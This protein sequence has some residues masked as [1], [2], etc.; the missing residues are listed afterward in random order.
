MKNYTVSFDIGTNSTGWACLDENYKILSKKMPV[1]S[2]VQPKKRVHKNFWGVSL[3]DAGKTAAETRTFRSTRRRYRRRK[4]RLDLLNQFFEDA[5]MEVDPNFLIRLNL[6]ST[7][8]EEP[9]GRSWDYILFMDENYKDSDYYKEFPTIYHLRKRLV[10][11]NQK[12]DIRLVYL[13]IHHILKYRGNFLYEDSFFDSTNE[14]V[15]LESAL[16]DLFKNNLFEL[17]EKN[18]DIDIILEKESVSQKVEDLMTLHDTKDKKHKEL[19]KLMLG[20][21]GSL[22]NLFDNE[23]LSTSTFTVNNEEWDSW[24]SE[25]EGLNYDEES[26]LLDIKKIFNLIQLEL[27]IEGASSEVSLAKVS[28]SMVTRYENHK[29]QLKKLK[30]FVKENCPR[31]TFIRIFKEESTKNYFGYITGV[32]KDSREKATTD[33]FYEFL[34]KELKE[35]KETDFYKEMIFLMDQREYLLKQRINVNGVI[36]HQ[37]HG[38][39]LQLILDNQ[40]KYYPFLQEHKEKIMAILNF[41]IPYYVGPLT[42][43]Q[44]MSPFAWM[45]KNTQEK[46]YP[47]NFDEVVNKEASA[48]EFINRMKSFDTYLPGES[49]L[50]KFS[51]LYQK[52][53]VLNEL[54]KIK[55]NRK[56]LTIENK[57]KIFNEIFKK[58]KNIDLGK[59]RNWWIQNNLGKN[60][61]HSS[62]VV[63]G[64]QKESSFAS[65]LSTYID[66]VNIFGQDVVDDRRNQSLLEEVVLNISLFEDKK[67]LKSRLKKSS[68][69]I[70]P[71]QMKQLLK[72]RYQGWGRL[73]QEF[74]DGTKFVSKDSEHPEKGVFSFIDVLWYTNL[75]LMQV[76]NSD[77]YDFKE[78]IKEAWDNSEMSDPL[79]LENIESIAGSPAIK[80][81]IYQSV[82]IIKEIVSITKEEPK[83]IVL[84]VA[85]EDG[86]KARPIDRKKA[87]EN[88]YNDLKNVKTEYNRELAKSLKETDKLTNEWLYL[89]YRQNGKCMYSGKSL[90]SPDSLTRTKLEIDHILPQSYI[91][92]DSLANKALVYREENQRKSNGLLDEQIINQQMPFWQT[93]LKCRL[94]T[95]DTFNRLISKEIREGQAKGF[96]NRQLV[97][98][99]QIIKNVAILFQQAYPDAEVITLKAKLTSDFRKKFDLPK[100]RFINNYHHAQDAYLNGV[101]GTMLARKYKTLSADIIYGDYIKFDKTKKNEM[102]SNG[103]FLSQFLKDQILEDGE[104]IWKKDVDIETVKKNFA[105][106]QCNFVRK[107]DFGT[108]KFFNETMYKKDSSKKNMYPLKNGK[109]VKLYGGYDSLNEYGMRAVSYKQDKKLIKSIIRVPIVMQELSD[110]KFIEYLVLQNPRWRDVKFISK[111]LPLYQLVN[112][113][114]DVKFISKILP[115]YQLVNYRSQ[116]VY[117]NTSQEQKIQKETY[118]SLKELREYSDLR[119][120]GSKELNHSYEELIQF[121]LNKIESSGYLN[122]K[123]VTEI[124]SRLN[125]IDDTIKEKVLNNLTTLFDINSRYTNLK[126]IGLGSSYGRKQIKLYQF[127]FSSL[128]L[129]HLSPTGLYE[130]REEL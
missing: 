43:N 96:I 20:N 106:V 110:E 25:Q 129:I 37:F 105:N 48:E 32:G 65:S 72:K 49:V 93:L 71:I 68:L 85:R 83:R 23:S 9:D 126:V 100:I 112:R 117:L 30:D 24:L 60:E 2:N 87:L 38:R 89:Y 103:F 114:R 86:K 108:G 26:I 80:R 120:I 46:I 76:I 19:F 3:F 18:E 7:S 101:I 91:K 47:W 81:G 94:I 13:A 116:N 50:P 125:D 39:E 99:R 57:Q 28:S 4:F 36:P 67:I 118:L 29:K 107:T 79:S 54:N 15:G 64:T 75:N 123:Q 104:I 127:K 82:K 70:T 121:L 53:E 52:Y 111:I 16:N 92:D 73:S 10:D 56:P 5:I 88:A 77:E 63:E 98:T 45:K 33:D 11:D 34:K 14:E 51:L 40:S 119:N 41:R 122:K 130:S 55:I 61:D 109:D 8:P 74:L 113:W 69:Q 31:E 59:I 62:I 1:V 22:K 42:D 90:G 21:K 95:R 124:K 58:Q 102:Q 35:F 128:E 27:I 17:T 44:E 115:L 12:Y 78:K 84:E 97:E 6:S 66:F